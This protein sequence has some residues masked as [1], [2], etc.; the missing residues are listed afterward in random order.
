MEW[1]SPNQKIDS[2]LYQIT[3]QFLHLIKWLSSNKDFTEDLSYA[4]Y[5]KQYFKLVL[6]SSKQIC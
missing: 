1:Y 3:H 5:A 4:E 6:F 2:T